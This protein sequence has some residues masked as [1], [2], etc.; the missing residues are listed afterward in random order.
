MNTEL[1]IAKRIFSDK[2]VKKGISQPIV[3]IAVIGIALG[4]AVMILSVAIV[5][6][7]QKQIKVGFP[8]V[9]P[10]GESFKHST[11]IRYERHHAALLGHEGP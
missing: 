5:T 4:L 8:V 3:S 2:S 7:F 10:T 1:F 11:L 6:G 9:M